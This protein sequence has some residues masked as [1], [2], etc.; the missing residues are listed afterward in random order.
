MNEVTLYGYLRVQAAGRDLWHR[1][2]H[3]DR[4]EMTVSWMVIIVVVIAAAV[5]AIG[6]WKT[7]F[8][9]EKVKLDAITT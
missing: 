4:G 5:A 1:M 9:A 3:D 2:R 6:V 8:D 7:L